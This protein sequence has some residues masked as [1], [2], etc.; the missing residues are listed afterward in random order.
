MKILGSINRWG[1]VDIKTVKGAGGG[2][3]KVVDELSPLLGKVDEDTRRDTS[4]LYE[5]VE[6][7]QT[8]NLEV[9]N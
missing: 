9:K 2:C 4:D 3:R 5:E 1:A 6:T 8:T 7:N